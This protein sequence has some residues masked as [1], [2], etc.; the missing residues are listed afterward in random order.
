MT[1]QDTSIVAIT[2]LA[3]FTERIF[4]K[5]IEPTRHTQPHPLHNDPAT[6][7]HHV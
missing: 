1:C 2:H 5:S 4:R 6:T 3:H 7:N